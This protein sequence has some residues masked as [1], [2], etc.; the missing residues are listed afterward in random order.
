MLNA[1]KAR[2]RKTK[3]TQEAFG[4][5]ISEIERHSNLT[6][7]ESQL[8]STMKC[9]VGRNQVYIR[10]LL[11][12]SGTTQPRIA[13][14]CKQREKIGLDPDIY[15]E[16]IQNTCCGNHDACPAWKDAKSRFDAL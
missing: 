2:P 16:Q 15:F 10:S 14:N 11:T 5:P 4:P 12:G 3:T 8:N 13:M 9:P 6:V 7:L 1:K